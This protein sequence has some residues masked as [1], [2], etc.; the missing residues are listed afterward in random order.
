MKDLKLALRVLLI[1]GLMEVSAWTYFFI[2]RQF[3]WE[4]IKEQVGPLYYY[5]YWTMFWGVIAAG[6]VIF[7]WYRSRQNRTG[8]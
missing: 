6:I 8:R 2:D 1:F 5:T 3:W 7:L 4:N